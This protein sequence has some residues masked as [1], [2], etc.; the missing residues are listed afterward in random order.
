M[1]PVTPD[2]QPGRI[3]KFQSQILKME[4][5]LSMPGSRPGLDKKMVPTNYPL[6]HYIRISLSDKT[7]TET[8]ITLKLK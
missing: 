4:T 2:S 6:I 8:E 1:T 7:N 5:A 3:T